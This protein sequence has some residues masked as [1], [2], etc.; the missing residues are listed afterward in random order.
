MKM[1]LSGEAQRLGCRGRAEA[2]GAADIRGQILAGHGERQRSVQL[3]VSLTLVL[4]RLE[5]AALLLCI[6]NDLLLC[7]LKS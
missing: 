3:Y 7:L 5:A 6:G 1:N 4:E 2:Q